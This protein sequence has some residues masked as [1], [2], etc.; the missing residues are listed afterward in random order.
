MAIAVLLIAVVVIVSVNAASNQNITSKIKVNFKPSQH[1]IGY[2]SATYTFGNTTRVMTSNGERENSDNDNVWFVYS[3][4]PTTKTLQMQSRDLNNGAL[5]IDDYVKE[6]LFAFTFKNTGYSDFT[7]YLDLSGITTKENVSLS[8]SLNN[9]VFINELPSI[10]VE[11]PGFSKISE[12]T[13]Y[14]KITIN[15]IAFDADFEGAFVWDL[16]A[17]ED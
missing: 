7:A 5:V 12:K 9:E 15:D 13:C 11:A 1:V 10:L 16:V 14:I 6:I 2:V 8:Y 4:K 17:E 3:E